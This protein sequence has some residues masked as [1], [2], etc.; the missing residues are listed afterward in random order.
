MVSQGGV[1]A[2]GMRGGILSNGNEGQNFPH[3]RK[4]MGQL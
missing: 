4:S 3:R 2:S 1:K